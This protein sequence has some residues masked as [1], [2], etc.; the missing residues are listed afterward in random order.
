MSRLARRVLVPLLIAL[1]LAAPTVG[2]RIE[3][4]ASTADRTLAR[5]TV[6]DLP[7]GAE[8]VVFWAAPTLDSLAIDD[9]HGL[10]VTGPPGEHSIAARVVLVDFDAR[11]VRGTEARH[12]LTIEGGPTPDPLPVPIPTPPE[13]PR[14]FPDP[15]TPTPTPQV[16]RIARAIVTFESSALTPVQANLLNSEA[17]RMALA[18][19]VGRDAAGWPL[20]KLWDKDVDLTMAPLDWRAAWD[21]V[22]PNVDATAKLHLIDAHGNLVTLPLPA[23]VE[24]AVAIIRDHEGR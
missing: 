2:Q 3:G 5:L 24:A 10:V 9:G 22:R 18:A 7:S 15:P 14:P 16:D 11:T 8:A 17:F 20:Y 4:P 21:L 13:P 19:A 1:A 6:V 23:T 12:A